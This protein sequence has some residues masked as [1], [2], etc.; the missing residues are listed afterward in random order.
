VDARGR[1]PHLSGA[2]KLPT[3]SERICRKYSWRATQSSEMLLNFKWGIISFATNN[4]NSCYH[5]QMLARGWRHKDSET[6]FSHSQDQESN[7][8][9]FGRLL[10][11]TSQDP[12]KEQ[13]KPFFL[14][15]RLVTK[16]FHPRKQTTKKIVTN[17]QRHKSSVEI[18]IYFVLIIGVWK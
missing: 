18:R 10:H 14:S 4:A 2:Q 9:C 8:E 17:K 7:Q 6:Y 12:F 1:H 13:G 16:L 5:N 3:F 15:P 11:L